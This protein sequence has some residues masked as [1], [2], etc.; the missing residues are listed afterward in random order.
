[1]RKIKL[2]ILRLEGLSLY[3]LIFPLLFIVLNS[4]R[5]VI[6]IGFNSAMFEKQCLMAVYTTNPFLPFFFPFVSGVY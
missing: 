1:M 4:T 3:S 2:R 5:S 6:N